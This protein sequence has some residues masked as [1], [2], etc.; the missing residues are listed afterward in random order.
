MLL[1]PK[2][3]PRYAEAHAEGRKMKERKKE[4]VTIF[5]ARLRANC[6]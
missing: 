6:V 5:T 2:G 3:R 1:N 4:G